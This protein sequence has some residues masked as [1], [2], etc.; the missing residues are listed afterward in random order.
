M[1][2]RSDREGRWTPDDRIRLLEED[3]DRLHAIIDQQ[4]AGFAS[5]RAEWH[6]DLGKLK[7]SLIGILVMLATAAVMLAANL[8]VR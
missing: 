7:G 5:E 4:Q 8:A 6:A 3:V 1:A 2:D